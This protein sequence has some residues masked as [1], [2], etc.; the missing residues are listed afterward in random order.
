[1]EVNNESKIEIVQFMV[2]RVFSTDRSK[3]TYQKSISWMTTSEI[4]TMDPNTTVDKAS[5]EQE[6]NIHLKVF[7]AL[8]KAARLSQG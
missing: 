7:S 4:E 5:A 8:G 1:M 2:K 3:T 6:T